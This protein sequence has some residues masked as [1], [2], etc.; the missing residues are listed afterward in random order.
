MSY[1]F[2]PT[3]NFWENFYDLTP[4]QKGINAARLEDF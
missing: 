2:K 1:R 4:S 3:E